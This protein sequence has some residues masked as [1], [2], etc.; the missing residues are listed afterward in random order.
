V[1]RLDALLSLTQLQTEVS[2]WLDTSQEPA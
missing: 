1:L 2:Q